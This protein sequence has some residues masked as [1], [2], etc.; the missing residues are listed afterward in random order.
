MPGERAAELEEEP[1]SYSITCCDFTVMGGRASGCCQRKWIAPGLY[2]AAEPFAAAFKWEPGCR[3]A[4]AHF[5]MS[6]PILGSKE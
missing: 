1:I 6:F 2:H 4:A 5:I 3:A